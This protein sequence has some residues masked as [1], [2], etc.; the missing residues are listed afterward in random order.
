MIN[1]NIP[2]LSPKVEKA[3]VPLN[4]FSSDDEFPPTYIINALEVDSDAVHAL[5]KTS[6]DVPGSDLSRQR[7]ADDAV[8]QT[9]WGNL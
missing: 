4:S 8:P 6:K 9:T 2:P 7:A 1:L 3:T 5:D